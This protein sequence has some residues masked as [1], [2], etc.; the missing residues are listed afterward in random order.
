[1][2]VAQQTQESIVFLSPAPARAIEARP[3][4][5][6]LTSLAGKAIG[7]LDNNKPGARPILDR[8]AER[9]VQ[10]GAASVRHWRKSHPSGPSPYV[11]EAA[12]ESDLVISGV[13]DCGSCSSWSLRD[14][15]E[16]E[17]TGVPTVTLVSKPFANV[18][19]IEADSLGMPSL[20]IF[21]TPHPIATLTEAE[22]HAIADDLFESVVRAVVKA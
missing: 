19:R 12:G 6:R 16:A 18:V 10:E 13:G 15:F 2:S 4:A 1:M 7:L 17:A 14:A 22:L 8:L 11:S 20:P 21:A 3:P 5:E 9:L